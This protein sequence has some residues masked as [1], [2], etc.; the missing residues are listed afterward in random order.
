MSKT[1]GPGNSVPAISWAGREV[2]GIVHMKRNVKVQSLGLIPLFVLC[3]AHFLFGI[4]PGSE[5]S[6]GKN[7]L[8]G[9]LKVV[10]V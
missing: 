9:K 3:L 8:P 10:T 7:R 4:D 1:R 5:E 2:L 6:E